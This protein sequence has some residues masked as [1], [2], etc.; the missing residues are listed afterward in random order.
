M[1]RAFHLKIEKYS[2]LKE[3]LEERYHTKVEILPV[4]V[5]SLGVVY[6][7]TESETERILKLTKKKRQKLMRRL[8]KATL[9]ESYK[10]RSKNVF[11][12]QKYIWKKKDCP[13]TEDPA[14]KYVPN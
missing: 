5:S 9:E 6:K 13:V 11:F 14:C 1:E 2:P 7:K 10:V 12:G 3:A 4:V 8:S